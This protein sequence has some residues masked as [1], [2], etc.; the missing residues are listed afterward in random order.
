[1]AIIVSTG[2]SKV[3]DNSPAQI[4][5]RRLA[6][7]L[8]KGAIAITLLLFGLL[9]R[10]LAY[11]SVLVVSG[12]MEPL[13]RKGDYTLVDHRVALRN[14]WQRGDVVV[15]QK[16]QAWDGS[17]ET[18]V[19]RVIGLPGET[20]ALLT[21]Q[22]LIN[23]VPIREPYL[24]EL[25]DSEDLQPVKLGADQYFMMGDNRNNS[26]DSRI[27]GPVEEKDI[28]GRMTMRLWPPGRFGSWS[29]PDYGS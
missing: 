2:A 10:V 12:S 24:K 22:V 7:V 5:K 15:F 23:G 4:E 21:G 20:V 6:R 26:G 9:L 19:K 14:A 28:R 13:V 17:D 18:L 8:T 27:N 25:P 3:P 1:M 11:E 29:R 16:P